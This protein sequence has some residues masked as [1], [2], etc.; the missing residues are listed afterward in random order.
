MYFMRASHRGVRRSFL[1][2]H[3]CRLEP[4]E[5][6]QLL[7]TVHSSA[8]ESG[9]SKHDVLLGLGELSTSAASS[10]PYVADDPTAPKIILQNDAIP[11]FVLNPTNTSVQSGNWSD[12]QTWSGGQV[13]GE[14][15][16]VQVVSGTTVVYDTISDAN[17]NALGVNP[18]GKLEFAIDRNTRLTLTT[19]IVFEGGT[20]QIGTQSNPLPVDYTAEIVVADVPLDLV[21]DPGQYGNGLLFFGKVDIFGNAV[22]RTWF[23]LLNQARAG[24][25]Q[26]KFYPQ[27][28]AGWKV[29]DTIILPDTRQ[30]PSTLA[31]DV[32]NKVPGVFEGQWE[33]AVIQSID[34]DT[35]TLTAPLQYDHIGARNGDGIL[36]VL[37]HVALLTRNIVIRSENPDGTRGHV[38]ASLRAEIDIRYARFKDLGRTDAFV[39]L[40]STVF[41]EQGNATYV[42]TNQIA[43]YSFHT[44]RLIGPV[45]TPASGYQFQFI[46]N[47]IDGGRKWGVTIHGTSFGL[48]KDNVAYDIDGAA[49][50][51]E[52][53][54]ETGNEFV[55]NF[56]MRIIGTGIDGES[57]IEEGDFGRGGVGFWARRAGNDYRD[58]VVAN[59]LFGGIVVAGK[60]LESVV[61]PI[62]PGADVTQPGEGITVTNSTPG[63]FLRNEVYGRTRF[64]IWIA[65]PTAYVMEKMDQVLEIKN[66][67]IWNTQGSA[68]SLEF[69]NNILISG[70]KILGDLNLLEQNDP[71]RPAMGI[72]LK[73]HGNLNLVIQNSRIE[74]MK[75]G[76]FTPPADEGAIP[77]GEMTIVR[78]TRLQNYA[79]VR[80][81][82]PK[83]STGKGL[84]LENV[85]WD[86]LA[87]APLSDLD[88]T[89]VYLEYTPTSGQLLAQDIVRVLDAN[90]DPDADY[91]L[92]YP[93]QRPDFIVPVSSP[94]VGGA[95]VP[96][97]TNAELWDQFGL[98]IGGAVSPCIGG[99]C[100]NATTAFE[101]NGDAFDIS[102]FSFI[103]GATSVRRDQSL[104]LTLI[105]VDFSS[106][107]QG[108]FTFNIDWDNDGLFDE[109]IVG[110]SGIT[111][112]Y[113]FIKHGLTTIRVVAENSFGDMSGE[114][115]FDVNVIG[116]ELLPNEE[117]PALTDFVW[118]GTPGDDK[119]Y[120]V[121]NGTTVWF[122]EDVIN[123]QQTSESFFL[124]G[125]TGEVII[126]GFD[127]NDTLA[128]T[129]TSRSVD[130][131]GGQG[132]DLLVGDGGDDFLDGGPGDD[133]LVSGDGN[134]VLFGGD[135]QDFL[136]SGPGNDLL[137]GQAGDDVLNGDAGRDILIGGEG[138][139]NL[140]GGAGEDLLLAD[141]TLFTDDPAGLDVIA[142]V[143]VYN[144]WNSSRTYQQRIDN[145]SG[146]GV[147]ASENGPYFLL[148]GVTVF[149]DNSSDTLVGS[150][151]DDWFFYAA[152]QGIFEGSPLPVDS[153]SNLEPDEQSVN[154]NDAPLW[155]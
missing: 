123:S 129:L 128:A 130:L 147:G 11:N 25:T 37:P 31:D 65:W 88:P 153:L 60:L 144:E 20:F 95:P 57:G 93:E 49:F 110:P 4:L 56:A 72:T 17:I 18:G 70:A 117:D 75:F 43:R 84:S 121:P 89:H 1:H 12:P 46:G 77:G 133:I 125:V 126:S 98:A 41:D 22:D 109:T 135:G 30:V 142:I 19:M 51:T 137:F 5:V 38:L 107:D 86:T 113:Q 52:N 108:D 69:T 32:K 66:S 140:N 16:I 83:S 118:Y 8:S 24:D 62:G 106:Y 90:G 29:G 44:H 97:L 131:I 15:A 119:A 99:A 64:G 155:W 148:P 114:A 27:V 122:L 61:I 96:G 76:I 138:S 6:R 67:L 58:N 120:F 116:Y 132:N 21:N 33:K 150:T 154:A 87:I 100:S 50:V 9:T 7:S 124:S 39:P 68:I 35:I 111:V 23:R 48:I 26:L 145:L 28:P 13:P 82:T 79:N 105:G 143:A 141:T 74:G 101:T 55:R 45:D 115:T 40:D 81:E 102:I 63:E 151:E 80:I 47:T 103:T 104:T 59:A 127:G 3:H 85:E 152:T 78:D 149:G 94:G 91:R 73:D 134:D 10:S 112:D 136:F 139:D 36:E 71:T 2:A 53:G 34:G 54:S 92:Y 42:G 146:V 14:G